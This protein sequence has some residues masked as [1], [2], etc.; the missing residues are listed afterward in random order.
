MKQEEN[1]QPNRL[2]DEKSPYLLQHAFN[3][4]DWHP[5]SEKAFKKAE[6]EDKPVFL[7]IGYSTCHWCHVMKKE[8]FEDKKV[9]ELLNKGFISIKVDR[10][11]RPDVDGF[12]MRICQMMTGSGGWPLTIIMTPDK[13]PFFAGTYIPKEA[14]LGKMGLL[15]LLQHIT[16]LWNNN[17]DRLIRIGEKA[18]KNLDETLTQEKEG[19]LGSH[20]LEEAYSQLEYEYDSI[21]GGFGTAPKFPIPHRLYFLL[22]YWHR[23]SEREALEM[24]E[25]TLMKMR[26][27]GIYDHIGF[28]FHRYSTDSSWLV[29]HFEKM[30][31][32]QALLLMAYVE[33]YQVTQNEF[34]KRVAEE[35]IQYVERDLSHKRGGFFSAEDS[36]SGGEEGKFYLWKETQLDESLEEK[37]A[38]LAKRIFNIKL[39]GNFREESSGRRVGKNILHISENLEDLSDQLGIELNELRGNLEK[40]RCKLYKA[41]EKRERPLLDDKILTD[42]NGLMIASLAKASRALDEPGYTL[43]A[44]KALEFILNE[45]TSETGLMHR[46]R[47]GEAAVN[48]FLDDYAFLI[49]GLIELYETTYKVDYLRRAMDLQDRMIELFWDDEDGGFYFTQMSNRELPVPSKDISDG[50]LPSGNSV[51]L[52]NLLK[53]SKISS[54]P[55]YEEKADLALKAFSGEIELNPQRHTMALIALDFYLGPGCEIIIADGKEADLNSDMIRLLHK[56]FYPRCVVIYKSEDIEKLLPFTKFYKNKDGKTTA[57]VCK[58]FSC[59]LPTTDPEEMNDMITENISL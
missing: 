11:E 21:N 8:S 26:L 2:I 17:R 39:E 58:N 59:K 33:V 36:E 57:Y 40:I 19:T 44:E 13:N 42:W 55:Y 49:W 18:V 31:Y 54:K 32:D 45:L 10:E 53:L 38:E 9:A 43:I 15:D 47:D 7:S 35:I 25:N 48:G 52:L 23:Y 5:W 4:V 3:P 12:Y 28:G 50:A 30:L 27:G 20:I 34:Y 1:K 41:R 56:D 14:R 16:Q 29:P 46:Y 22:R 24:V 6:N 37:E 51:A